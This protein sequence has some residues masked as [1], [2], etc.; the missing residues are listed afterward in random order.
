MG[1]QL[2]YAD[3][4]LGLNFDVPHWSVKGELLD[5]KVTRELRELGIS[6]HKMLLGHWATLMGNDYYGLQEL[7]PTY[8]RPINNVT[9]TCGA[10]KQDAKCTFPRAD[11]APSTFDQVYCC[12]TTWNVTRK[13]VTESI[14]KQTYGA[15][16]KVPNQN[17]C[18]AMNC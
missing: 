13:E 17:G 2:V 18:H 4:A 5:S 9:F 12:G 10:P 7:Y 6:Q 11:L 3:P 16:W 14:L 15:S 1:L 8:Y